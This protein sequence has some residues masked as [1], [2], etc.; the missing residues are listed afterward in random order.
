MKLLRL[1]TEALP[2][3]RFHIRG[4]DM[5]GEESAMKQTTMKLIGPLC[6]CFRAS[7]FW[8]LYYTNSYRSAGE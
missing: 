7:I 4:L 3:T 8:F 1:G 6:L 5:T 2:D